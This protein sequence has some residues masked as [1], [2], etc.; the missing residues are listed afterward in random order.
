M[1]ND[2]RTPVARSFC[3]DCAG[4]M[5]RDASLVFS[6]APSSVH[7]IIVGGGE[8]GD[9]AGEGGGGGGATDSQGGGGNSPFSESLVL[10]DDPLLSHL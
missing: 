7:L 8:G 6:L 9:L 4:G 5:L 2:E 3:S 1:S 10:R